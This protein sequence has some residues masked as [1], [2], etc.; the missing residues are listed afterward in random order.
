[1][2][3]D[4]SLPRTSSGRSLGRAFPFS[5]PLAFRLALLLVLVSGALSGQAAHGQEPTG[6]TEPTAALEP[7]NY[8][9]IGTIAAPHG[10]GVILTNVATGDEQLLAVLPPVGVSGHAAWSPD[11]TRLAI[12]RFGRQPGERVGGSDILVLPAAGGEALP[13]AAHDRDG[14]LLGAPAWLPDSTGLYYDHLPPSGGASTAQVMFAPMDA[15]QSVRTIAP[16]G[17]PAVSPNGLYLAYVRPSPTMGFLNELVLM[18]IA[19]GVTRTLVPADELIQITSPRFSPDGT[20]IAFVG[21]TSIGE[22]LESSGPDDLQQLFVKAAPRPAESFRGVMA[23]GPPGD[24]WVMSVMGGLSTRLTAFEE[25]EPTLAWS[26]D[27]Y[28]LA[29]MGGGGLYLMPRDRSQPPHKL[30]KGGFGGID[31]R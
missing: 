7:G 8:G 12:S 14:A 17:W 10:A 21:S 22:A 11:R 2:G 25:D 31:W 26:P 15:S 24:I 5:F 27:G 30:T 29:M 19:S 3:S 13:V 16:G 23:H 28:W 1:M 18:D 4:S 9:P 20:E 6:A